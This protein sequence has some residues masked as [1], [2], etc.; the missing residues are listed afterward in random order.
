ME[1]EVF[2]M[3]GCNGSIASN[4]RMQA[5]E[6]CNGRLQWKY[7]KQWKTAMENIHTSI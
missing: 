3:E 1:F 2:T 5:M 6:D 7:C 4:G